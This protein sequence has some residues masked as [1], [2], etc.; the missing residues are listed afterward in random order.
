MTRTT[1]SQRGDG[2]PQGERVDSGIEQLLTDAANSFNPDD[3][4]ALSRLLRRGYGG[5][6]RRRTVFVLFVASSLVAVSAGAV[7]ISRSAHHSPSRASLSARASSPRPSAVAA[8]TPA[9]TATRSMLRTCPPPAQDNGQSSPST[10]PNST[11]SPNECQATGGIRVTNPIA[12]CCASSTPA[13]SISGLK[14]TAGPIS[15]G[16]AVEIDGRGLGTTKRVTFGD[17]DARIAATSDTRL[18]VTV[19][20]GPA[21]TERVV[22]TVYA[23]SGLARAS[24]TYASPPSV[25]QVSPSTGSQN[26]GNRVTIYGENFVNVTVVSFGHHAVTNFTTVSPNELAVDAPAS[27]PGTVDVTVTAAGG[28]SSSSSADRYAYLP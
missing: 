22:V 21:R 24:Y 12:L 6:Q 17:A 18:Q 26:G 25:S 27:S 4:A 9:P 15:G 11:M 5:S 14:P 10:W 1:T 3:R 8:P 23:T 13:V 2:M 7:A 16:N 19:P 28:T 20:A